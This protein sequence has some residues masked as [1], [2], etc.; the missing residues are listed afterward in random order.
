[1]EQL[2][3]S[4]DR[5]IFFGNG[6]GNFQV[7][8]ISQNPNDGSIYFSAPNFEEIEW[9]VPAIVED[10]KP[11]L[12]RYQAAAQ[13]KLSLH[14][15]GVTHVRPYESPQQNVF[16]IRGNVLRSSDT[17]GVRHL[18][19]IFLSE[20]RHKPN[21]QA[22]ARRSDYVMNTKQWHPYVLILWAAPASRPIT[23]TVRGSFHEDELEEVPPNGGWGAFT[24]A[25]HSI[26]WFAYRTKHMER[27]PRNA[28]ACYSDGHTVP[29]FIGTGP[30]EFRL[31][32]RKPQYGMVD[33]QIS[34]AL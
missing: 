23:V 6:A 2:A 13:G 25:L 27:W 30:G 32:Y 28:Q 17:L 29:V 4:P 7:F 34:I 33:N 18:V 9:I 19:T 10:Q 20:P 16:S 15:S 1:M 3:A 26:V 31:E 21:S 11:V 5:R 14:G 8:S 12:L 24:M 22:L